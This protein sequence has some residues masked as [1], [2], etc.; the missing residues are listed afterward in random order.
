MIEAASPKPETPENESAVRAVLPPVLSPETR[1]APAWR[2]PWLI[3]V[4]IAL[5]LAGW[6]WLETRSRLSGMQKEVAKR[7]SESDAA[8]RDSRAFVRQVQEQLMMLQGKVGELEGRLAESRSQQAALETLYQD[9]ARGRE[10]WVLGEVEQGVTLAAQQLQLA[11][12]VQ[13]AVM[14]LQASENRLAGSDRPHHI[15]L[16][17]VL[18]RDLTRLRALPQIDM[19][20]M[21][22]QIETLISS[23]DTLPLA[24]D[25]R[26]RDDERPKATARSAPESL[27][28][29]AFWQR[30]GAEFWAELRGL[31]RI[32]RFDREEPAL[33]APGQDFFL[34]EN[35]KLRLLNAR[36]ALLARDQW[37]FR[38]E[39]KLARSWLD[40][41]FDSRQIS[42][43]TAQESFRQLAATAISL[44]LPS[45]NESLSAVRNLRQSRDRK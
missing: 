8:A 11:G 17:K 9:L 6:Q 23:I 21:N 30:L 5:T 24:V 4:V 16:R 20:G 2:N 37:T 34:R 32:Q 25:G 28:D 22:L 41:Y 13:G 43:Q 36:L 33:L 29:L 7:L 44:E 10:E 14:A 40:R 31:V 19:A 42:V 39:L 35:L 38:N 27:L 45:L 26:S 12:N 15:A 18:A 3:V 1:P